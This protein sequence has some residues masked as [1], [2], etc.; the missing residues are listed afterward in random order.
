MT[1]TLWSKERRF[2]DEQ[3]MGLFEVSRDRPRSAPTRREISI[4]TSYNEIL[5]KI[6]KNP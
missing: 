5:M 4:F 3:W 2:L 1:V 6:G